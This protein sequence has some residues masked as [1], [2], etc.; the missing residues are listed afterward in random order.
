LWSSD[1]G[2][3]LENAE[4]A[5]EIAERLPCR[6]YGSSLVEDVR[7]TAWGY[8]GNSYRVSSD[9]WRAEQSFQAAWMHHV[10]AGEDPYTEGELLSLFASLRYSQTRLSEAYRMLD[11]VIAIY[12]EGQDCQLESRALIQKGAHLA[13]GGRHQEALRSIH[14][15]L[16]KG[17]VEKD[18]QLFLASQHNLIYLFNDTGQPEKASE[19]LARKRV[20]YEE[21]GNPLHLIRLRWLEGQIA[22]NLGDLKAAE[23]ALRETREA[24]LDQKLGVRVASISLEL[25]LLHAKQGRPAK[26]LEEAAVVIPFFDSCGLV[27]EAAAARLLFERAKHL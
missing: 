8:L 26:V 21:Y 6:R 10:Q 23:A 18:P 9:L 20:L 15:G 1:P 7:A 24:F 13:V 5:V 2:A 4:L 17:D 14:E 19:E 22:Q 16:R 27:R 25:M 3:A 12:R 11:R